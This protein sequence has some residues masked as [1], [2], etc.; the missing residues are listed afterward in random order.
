MF[1]SPQQASA[2]LSDQPFAVEASRAEWLERAAAEG[3]PPFAPPVE[4]TVVTALLNDAAALDRLGDALHAP[5]YK[6]PPVAPVLAIKPRNAV[7][8][9]RACVA[10]PAEGVEVGATLG[11]VVGRTTCRV[12][13]ADALAHVAGYTIVLD[14]SLSQESLYRPGLRLR[15]RDGF[16]PIGPMV[17]ARALV[18]DPD[19][20]AVAVAVDGVTVW[21][22]S[23]GGRLRGVARLLADVSEFMTLSPG[24]VLALGAADGV[25]RARAGQEVTVTID[26]LGTLVTQLVAE[27]EVP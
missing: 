13:A 8:G 20:L 1:W 7:V 27:E 5:P 19:A 23:T 15:A 16:C 22:G 10:V 2:R 11:I 26:G 24:D 14:L 18:V 3:G 9:H 17:V 6:A 4:G 12:V 21:R 25:P